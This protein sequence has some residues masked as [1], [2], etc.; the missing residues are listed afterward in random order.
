MSLYGAMYSGVS[1]LSAESS[2]LGAISDNITNVN[3]VGYKETNVNFQT[4]VTK[5]VSLSAYSPG[6]VQ[7]KPRSSADVQ[8]LLQSTS[9]STDVAISGTGFF[10]V[11]SSSQPALTQSGS[12]AYTR[13]GSFKVDKS[14]Y[15]QNVA[16]WY[17]QGWPLANW[18][19]TPTAAHETINGNDYMAAYKDT[20]GN[21]IYINESSQPNTRD[22]Q[23]LNLNGIA[24][25]ASSTTSIKMGA[26]LP[27]SST[28]GTTEQTSAQIYDSL[29][30]AHNI[31]MTWTALTQNSWAMESLPPEGA[32]NIEMYDSSTSAA[33]NLCSNV[34]RLDF[35]KTPVA[36]NTPV[37][38]TLNGATYNFF[39]E[40]SA[41]AL[42]ANPPNDKN[43]YIDPGTTANPTSVSVFSANVAAAMQSAYDVAYNSETLKTS[44]VGY[45]TVVG[46]NLVINGV[47][48]DLHGLANTAAVAAAINNVTTATA[49]QAGT[50]VKAV[51][52]AAGDLKLYTKNNGT[53]TFGGSGQFAG[54]T[55]NTAGAA[56]ASTTQTAVLATGAALGTETLTVNG[57]SIVLTAGESVA[58][59]ITAINN[60]AS[61][62]GVYATAVNGNANAI[63]FYTDKAASV[64]VT[65][66][67][68]EFTAGTALAAQAVQGGTT[69]SATGTTYANQ[70]AGTNSVVFRQFDQ[71]NDIVLTG[72][73]SVVDTT[74]V[75]AI[76]QA[77]VIGTSAQPANTF[78]LSHLA[79]SVTSG[80]NSQ[81]TLTPD[82]Y[83]ST[84]PAIVFNGDGTPQKIFLGEIKINWANGSEDMTQPGKL[85]QGISPPISLFIGNTNTSDGMTQLSGSYQLSYMTQ[86]GAKFG[87]FSGVSIGSD[88]VVTALFDNGVTRPIFQIP[89][90]TFVNPNGLEKL[91]GNVFISTDVSGDPTL[92]APGE[93]GSGQTTE[94]SLESSTVDIGTQF[95]TMIVTQRAYSAA[96]KVITTANQMLDDLMQVVR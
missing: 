24:G 29:G 1:G 96:S 45:P 48:I 87:N 47:N 82:T 57:A 64:N 79:G 75:Y 80:V 77:N 21:Y 34:G 52:D 33:P 26:N 23:P 40:N 12:Y 46:D 51:V 78:T 6:G 65:A 13:A 84:T 42:P 69:I 41:N 63:K 61:T 85:S 36:T 62:T 81:S 55:T 39:F 15:L 25:T 73:T 94:S 54:A 27:A 50:G 35:T 8:G 49:T 66:T 20:T 89:I 17:L 70:V 76:E 88:G 32:R 58:N 38:M 67:G 16:G 83:G 60:V 71:T 74:G 9:S 90:A 43:W 2:A 86:N 93:A 18:D 59:V 19:S 72:L 10:I 31:A 30:N 3:T 37:T 95:T 92:R 14:G 5:Q 44:G 4:L 28:K 91:T 56:A 53:M 68:G 11:N 7:S 22:L